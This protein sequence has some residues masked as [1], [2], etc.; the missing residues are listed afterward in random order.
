MNNS[1]HNDRVLKIMLIFRRYKTQN[2]NESVYNKK[3][4]GY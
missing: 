4:V 3:K 1:I 2:D